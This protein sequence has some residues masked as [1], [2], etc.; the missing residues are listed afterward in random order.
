MKSQ[1]LYLLIIGSERTERMRIQSN[2][3]GLTES[4]KSTEMG[5]IAKI[6]E[7]LAE[8][9]INYLPVSYGDCIMFLF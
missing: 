9:L 2:E 4:E 5:F 8:L 3:E 6:F 1:F 7:S